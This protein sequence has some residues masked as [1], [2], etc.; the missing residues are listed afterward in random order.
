MMFLIVLQKSWWK[1]KSHMKIERITLENF[2]QYF[3]KHRISLSQN[4]DQN[5]TVIHGVNGAG[6]TSFFLALN[7]C[8]YG[9]GIENIGQIISKEAVSRA[10][11]GEIIRSEVKIFFSHSGYRYTA[12]RQLRGQKKL[13]GSV[14]EILSNSEFIL[15]RTPI[16]GIAQ[17]IDN[18]I[19]VMNTILPSNV[20]TYFFFDGEKI[21]NFARP[22]AAKEVQKAIYR[23]LSLDLLTRTSNHLTN[24]SRSL[25]GQ[26]KGLVSDELKDL[27]SQEADLLIE[28]DGLNKDF[29]EINTNIELANKRIAEINQQL[30]DFNEMKGLQEQYDRYSV[31]IQRDER[32]LAELTA[33]IRELASQG[34]VNMSQSAVAS[35]LALLDEKRKRG[36]IP[37]NIREQ[38]IEDIL[39][40]QV[41]ICGRPFSEH[42]DAYTHLQNLIRTAVP[43]SLE[44]DVL[45]TSSSLRALEILAQSNNENLN[46]L[47]ASKV[48]IEQNIESLYR[49]RDDIKRQMSDSDFVEA[50]RLA[51]QREE[52]SQDIADYQVD[53]GRKQQ[54]LETIKTDIKGLEKKI[55]NAKKQ[56]YQSRLIAQKAALARDAAE[57]VEE[58]YSTFA[59]N[60]RLEVEQKTREIFHSLAW[61]GDHFQDVR[62]TEEYQLEVIDRYGHQARPELSAGERQVLS[63][64]F[65]AAMARAA[66]SEAPLIMDT[67][68]GRL[69]SAHRE[70]ITA[71]LPSLAPQLVLFVTDEELRDQA[72]ENLRPR[73]GAEYQL[74]F[75]PQTSCTQIEEVN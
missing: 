53:I 32:E 74:N 27:L 14:E 34:Y 75:N 42:E 48:G 50:S 54:R 38:F 6:K 4:P 57:V 70:A 8:L 36:E 37:S 22:E 58:V 11:T 69:S 10:S 30:R 7:W 20:R 51:N 67:P 60:K 1:E 9:E 24:A 61:K 68:F 71:K 49:Q 25:R 23:V 46:S 56:D 29:E 44:D 26:L 65:I 33:K 55:R 5:V 18:P 31:D 59:E 66:E 21:D 73:I 72:L 43:S 3:G 13:N 47:M 45:T 17:K 12:S 16:D 64:S 28:Q 2:R 62:L 39:A 19:G 52:Y 40:K 41:C 35:A 63:L 15:M